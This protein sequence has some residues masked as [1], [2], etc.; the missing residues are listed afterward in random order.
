MTAATA[1]PNRP[2]AVPVWVDRLFV[3]HVA[4]VVICAIW[5]LSEF[6]GAGV[7]HYVGI[8]ADSPS[9]LTSFLLALAAARAQPPGAPRKAW[10]CLSI[11]LGL[12]A[13][14]TIGGASYLLRDEDPFPGITDIFFIG[15]YP[16]FFAGA[17]YLIRAA[18]ARV[19]WVR[20]ALDSTILIIGFGTFFWFLAIRHAASDTEVD[21]I[22][23]ALSQAYLALNCIVQLTLGVLLL[24]CVGNREG[25]RVPFCC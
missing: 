25:R 5:M 19:P 17:L 14:G 16:A 18:A 11:S 1:Q 12:Y 3:A 13:L 23:H 9:S 7:I 21:V 2:H 6:G 4:Y 20:L 10:I 22:K 15:F 8:L 24:T